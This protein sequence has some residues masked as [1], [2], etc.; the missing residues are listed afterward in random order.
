M[1]VLSLHTLGHDTGLSY[2]EAGR[3]VFSIETERLTRRKHDPRGEIALE[4]FATHFP[5]ALAEI[6]LVAL[7]TEIRETFVAVDDV[8]GCHRTIA[9]GAT[10]ATSSCELLGRRYPCLVVLHEASHAALAYHYAGTPDRCLVFVNEGRG[11]LTRN[12]LY[13]CGPDRIALV[14]RDRLPWFCTGFGWT[15]LGYLFGF[16]DDPSAAGR[17][18]AVG[19]YGR[20]SGALDDRIRSVDPMIHYRGRDEQRREVTKLVDLNGSPPPF[21]LMADYISTF[22]Q[23]FTDGVCEY[24]KNALVEH[25]ATHLALGGGCALNLNA[26]AAIRARVT[27]HVGIGPACNDAGQAL[28]VA[29]YA[30][31][32]HLGIRPE[33]FTHACNGLASPADDTRTRVAALGLKARAYDEEWL[34]RILTDG[35]VVAYLNRRSDIGPRSLGNR[36]LYANPRIP[37]M[38]RRVSEQLKQREWFRPLSP[39]MTRDAF[40]ALVPGAPPSPYMLFAYDVPPMLFPEAVHVDGSAR[41]QTVTPSDN[42][43]VHGLVSA[44]QRASGVPA[45]INTSLNSRG[46]AMAYTVD[47]ALD[48]F[49]GADV[50][51]FVFDEVMALNPKREELQGAGA[52]DVARR[53]W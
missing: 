25:D 21:D 42:A 24:L 33:P 29:I 37:G 28:G 11:R 23:A 53:A 19:G 36:S 10:H 6:D 15:A 22:Q 3:L 35:A 20:S 48:D 17:L 13:V 34:A 51:V 4:Y 32:F 2:W 50:D 1:K 7:S 43:R 8:E 30:H 38:R 12:S 49:L 39:L 45:L 26:N 5:A 47:D 14:D 31:L 46:R 27:P 41:I 16:G 52:G 44:F 40:E 18:M 9:A